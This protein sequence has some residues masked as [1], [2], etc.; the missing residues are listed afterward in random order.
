[1][2]QKEHTIYTISTKYIEE[3]VHRKAFRSRTISSTGGYVLSKESWI[4]DEYIIKFTD[5]FPIQSADCEEEPIV[6]FENRVVR[7]VSTSLDKALSVLE[8]KVYKK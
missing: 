1:M 7:V 3:I 6:E 5:D 8:S 4:D 2:G